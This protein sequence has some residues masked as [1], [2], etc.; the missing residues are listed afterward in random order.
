MVAAEVAPVKLF[1]RRRLKRVLVDVQSALDC[2][3][4]EEV[5][6]VELGVRDEAFVVG[7]GYDGIAARLVEVF[8]LLW[9]EPA[10]GMGRV[11]VEVRTIP[12][13]SLG[14]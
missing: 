11:A 4:G 8:H 3:E 7:I 13:Y 2:V 6:V 9:R 5:V 1:S 12:V 14:K 10:V